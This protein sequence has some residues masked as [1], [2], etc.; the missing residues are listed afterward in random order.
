[1]A[2]HPQIREQLLKRLRSPKALYR[3]TD[4][5]R[6]RFPMSFED[7]AYVI[8]FQSG[9]NVARYLDRDT[10]SRVQQH[11]RS[12]RSTEGETKPAKR[13]EKESRQRN[14]TVEVKVAGIRAEAVPHMRPAHAQ[15]GKRMA[16]KAFLPLYLFENSARDVIAGVLENAYGKNWWDVAA[17][18]SL[19]ARA[20]RHKADEDKEAWHSARGAHPINYLLLTDLPALVRADKA[21][22]HFENLFPRATWFESI[23]AD[24]NVSRRVLAHMN[25]IPAS[26]IQHI[27]SSFAKWVNQ[28]RAK[29]SLLP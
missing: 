2:V 17:T 19:K 25:P 11:V 24:L 16:Q 18:R 29:V 20:A 21:W 5:L 1:M 4:Q 6:K 27:E 13:R 8:A 12:L 3:S 26:D 15:D 9:V 10:L 22:P 28:L 7:A 14:K 23:V